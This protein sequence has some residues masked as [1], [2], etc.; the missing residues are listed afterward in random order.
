MSL[1]K[2]I[3]IPLFVIV[4]WKTNNLV[5]SRIV[6]ETEVVGG[7]EVQKRCHRV[8]DWDEG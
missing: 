4:T 1:F 7:L 3:S 2:G 6:C 8:S 5:E